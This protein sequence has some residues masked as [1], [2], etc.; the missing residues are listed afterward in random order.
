MLSNDFG[1]DSDGEDIEWQRKASG[2]LIE[3]FIDVN[4]GE[5]ELMKM[6]NYFISKNPQYVFYHCLGACLATSIEVNSCKYC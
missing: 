1:T 4:R 2:Q 5:K 6:W 3:E